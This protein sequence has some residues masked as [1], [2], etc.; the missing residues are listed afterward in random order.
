MLKIFK[1][2]S[3]SVESF[4]SEATETSSDDQILFKDVLTHYIEYCN[5][6]TIPSLSRA[7]FSQEV[8][9]LGFLVEKGTDN[10]TFIKG[11][12]WN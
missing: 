4:I 7:K 9:D 6:H 5:K 10:K 11:I 2:R 1:I 3:S 8:K 12:S